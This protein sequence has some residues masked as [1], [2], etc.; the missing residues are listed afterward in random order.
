MEL[1]YGS[2]AAGGRAVLRVSGSH[3]DSSYGSKPAQIHKQP[4]LGR[5]SNLGATRID[6]AS[7]D[8]QN[9]QNSAGVDA[10]MKAEGTDGVAS[11]EKLDA[12]DIAEVGAHKDH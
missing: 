5:D 1:M 3:G 2:Q 6:G 8:P 11:T 7:I 10:E 9:V 12:G 4:S